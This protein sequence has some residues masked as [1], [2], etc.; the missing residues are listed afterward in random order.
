MREWGMVKTIIVVC[1][2]LWAL[3]LAGDYAQR[4][5]DNEDIAVD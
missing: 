5:M 2:V 1:L 4:S 3:D